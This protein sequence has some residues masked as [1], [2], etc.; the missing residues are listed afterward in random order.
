MATEGRMWSATSEA[1]ATPT[2]WSPR[3]RAPTS[4]RWIR[5]LRHR[6][7]RAVPPR[8]DGALARI[9]ERRVLR[10]C[11]EPEV[12]SVLSTCNAGSIGWRT[13]GLCR[14]DAPDPI[15]HVLLG[16]HDMVPAAQYGL[17]FQSD[18]PGAMAT[19]VVR[20]R[21]VGGDASRR[22]GDGGRRYVPAHRDSR[23][24]AAGLAAVVAAGR[25]D[26]PCRDSGARGG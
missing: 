24:L 5:A 13:C 26:S 1:C 23:R 7:R 9:A 15:L 11:A 22:L 10:S 16:R 6:R 4:Q 14:M 19:T 21:D 20:L 3:S 8:T 17:E 25:L 2:G 18:K 12:E